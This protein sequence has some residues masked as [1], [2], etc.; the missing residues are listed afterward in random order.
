M[1]NGT[2]KERIFDNLQPKKALF[3]SLSS[4]FMLLKL[5][6]Y[7]TYLVLLFKE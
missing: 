2:P 4:N 1:F 7:N 6:Y 3:M 5:D